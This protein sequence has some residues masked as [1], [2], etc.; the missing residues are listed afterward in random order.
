MGSNKAVR[1]DTYT[2]GVITGPHG[3]TGTAYLYSKNLVAGNAG[4]FLI[5]NPSTTVW[6]VGGHVAFALAPTSS[7]TQ[8]LV[9]LS[10][11][12]DDSIGFKSI[13]GTSLTVLQAFVDGSV[14][15]SGSTTVACNA[16]GTLGSGI[17]IGATN[18]YRYLIGFNPVTGVVSFGVNGVLAASVTPGT[19]MPS[20]P[21][22][23]SI[24]MSGLADSLKVHG[25]WQGWA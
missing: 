2:G 10:T 22:S 7:T 14:S 5:A 1:D 6:G 8:W 15:G 18:F 16:V 11:N 21:M 20:S 3:G 17:T 13:G 23:A 25:L 19:K 4:Q 9:Q 12:V 24:V